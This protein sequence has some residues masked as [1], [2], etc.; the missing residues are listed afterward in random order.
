MSRKLQNL[1]KNNHIDRKKARKRLVK[2]L[3]EL[4]EKHGLTYNKVFVKNQK[5]R[6]GSCSGC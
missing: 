1:K 3:N 5:T 4:S 2:R 6:W